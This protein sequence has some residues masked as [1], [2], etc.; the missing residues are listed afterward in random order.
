M[1]TAA[2]TAVMALAR[3]SVVDDLVVVDGGRRTQ[4]GK[5][6]ADAFGRPRLHAEIVG[7]LLLLAWLLTR[8][9]LAALALGVV[10]LAF[11]GFSAT[12][13]AV[14]LLALVFGVMRAPSSWPSSGRISVRPLRTFTTRR[15]SRVR[16]FIASI[17]RWKCST[18]PGW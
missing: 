8:G 11:L 9:R 18:S 13:D 7:P 4:L 3:R 16:T 17:C 5:D 14:L 2:R 12:F 1:N 10:P 15:F 6:R